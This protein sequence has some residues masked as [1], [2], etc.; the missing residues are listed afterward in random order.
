MQRSSQLVVVRSMQTAIFTVVVS[1]IINCKDSWCCARVQLTNY[2]IQKK[3]HSVH[4][5]TW[6]CVY[7]YSWKAFFIIKSG[8]L[9]HYS[10]YIG[11]LV[12]VFPLSIYYSIIL[13]VS[14]AF[15]S[16]KLIHLTERWVKWKIQLSTVFS[17]ILICWKCP[18]QSAGN[19]ISETLKLRI[20]W[21]SM[22]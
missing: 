3:G 14:L 11:V 15:F 9:I 17:C 8:W 13:M 7:M 5:H 18:V 21:G 10:H 2:I 22:L 19:G 12:L 1:T 6:T 16:C 4:I 20:C